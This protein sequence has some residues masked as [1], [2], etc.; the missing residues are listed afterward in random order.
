MTE[1]PPLRKNTAFQLLWLGSAT[2]EFG[3]Q[4]TRLAMPLLV[5]AVTGSPLWAGL[6]AGAR[7][8]ATVLAQMPAG[9]W[10]DRWD[11]RRTL[12]ASQLVQAGAAAV[13]AV[14][15]LT[16]HPLMWMF[17]LLAVVDGGCTAFIG[18][19]RSVAVRGVVPP[20]QLRAAYTQEEARTHAAW[21]AGPPAGGLLYG[22]GQAVPFVVDAVTFL[23]S[24]VCTVFARVP[25]RP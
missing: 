11:R 10:V 2:S 6:V 13:L 17:L 4:L 21:L 22:L 25:R 1:T 8:A 23:V 12:V 16:G 9:V 18:P 14:L 15:I 19:A 7:S 20:E 24:A 5:L 3:T